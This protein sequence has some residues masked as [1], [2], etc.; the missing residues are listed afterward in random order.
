MAKLIVGCGYL[1]TRV[2][3]RWRAR[4]EDVVVT[5]R[6]PDR[7]AELQALG[8]RPLVCDVLAPETLAQL[9]RV[10][11]VLYAVALDRT[12]GASRRQ[13]YVDGLG[14]V[15]DRLPAPTRFLHVSSTSVYGQ[16]SGEEVDETAATEPLDD[17]GRVVLEAER[18]LRARWP[19]AIIL[20]FAGIYGP[21]RLLRQRDL[22]AGQP[23]RT[24]PDHWLNLIHVD[25]GAAAILAADARARPGE[26][27][28][29]S[30]GHP[31][32]RRDFYTHLAQLLHA[33]PPT[34]APPES[35][36]ARDR[37]DRRISNRKLRQEL[38][39]DLEYPSYW[40]GLVSLAPE[41]TTRSPERTRIKDSE[42]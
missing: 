26:V 8:L 10:D 18:L 38:G 9:P 23:L 17:S 35:P 40:E 31:V 36:N 41:A 28:N 30:D 22:A 21:G 33:P 12:T 24:D 42:D 19:G 14:H 1:G 6:R 34:F 20:R 37:A 5:T 32:R 4:G 3:Q 25:D 15:L 13:V 11:T 29:V 2:A 27:Y 39:V 16:T 7:A